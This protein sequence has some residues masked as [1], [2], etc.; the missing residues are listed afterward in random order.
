MY[1]TAINFLGA[2]ITINKN[3]ILIPKLYYRWCALATFS[4]YLFMMITSY[5]YGQKFYPVPYAKKKL[6][7]YLTLA[8]LVYLA[9][10]GLLMI[11]HNRWFNIASA[12][13]LLLIFGL[14]ILKIERKEFQRLPVIGKWLAPKVA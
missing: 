4:C 12:T 9:H 6:L 10:R 14:F 5:I 2:V 1:G 11:D 3:I 8:T 7:A 13:A